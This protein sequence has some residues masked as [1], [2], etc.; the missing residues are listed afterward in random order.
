MNSFFAENINHIKNL[1]KNEFEALYEFTEILNT[2]DRQ[3]SLIENAMD[4]VI[5]V[6]NAERG[7]FV[8]YDET[9]DNFSIITARKISNENITDLNQFSSGILQKVIKEK[10]PLLYHDVMGDPNLSQFH[11]VQIH[12]IKSVIGVP[13]IRDGKIWGV[14]IADS[15]LDRRE[16]TDE[17]LIFLNFFSNL[18]SLALERIIKLEELQRENR[19]LINKLQATEEIPEMIGGSLTMR[20]LAQLIYKVAQTDATV[21]IYG[22]SGTGKEV[23][24]KAIHQL[25]KR[26]AA[27]FLAQFCG[28]IPDSLLESELFGYKKGA[29]TGANADKQGLIEA[30]DSGTF[31]LDEIAD[32]SSALQ[33]K[34]LRVLENREIIRLGDTKVKRVD[35]R[36]LAATNKDLI[37]L[38]KEGRFREDLFYRLNVFPIKMPP[39]RERREDI[40]LLAK[41]FAK[42][43][44]RADVYIDPSAIKKLENYYWP[45]NI[46]QLINVIQRAL[47]LCD[48]NKIQTEHI[49]LE[50]SKD[51]TDF[52]GTL[53]EFE[54]L[55]LKKRLSEFNG[56]RT[57]TAKSLDVSVRW[58]QLKLKELGE[59]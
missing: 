58:I 9:N 50:D 1:S 27:P 8:R 16:F 20:N 39:L 59:Q 51:L 48:T 13:I 37:M 4:I 29:F 25:S 35:V 30:A 46:R 54:M 31:F 3:E 28:S 47:I 24:A 43:L 10:K 26:K 55:L 56:N 41:H 11:S 22:E 23:T 34:L 12:K 57:L 5:K 32:I 18:V 33:A 19:I 17:N 45:G 49:I 7:L 53:Q 15:T 52:N 6:I 21:L 14:I 38:T 2:A 36:I 42:K 40:P 44:G